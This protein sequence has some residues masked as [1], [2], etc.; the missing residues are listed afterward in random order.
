[1]EEERG[2]CLHRVLSY[3]HDVR[4][5]FCFVLFCFIFVVLMYAFMMENK[6]FPFKGNCTETGKE[7]E[8]R[9]GSGRGGYPQVLGCGPVSPFV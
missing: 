4:K 2:Q 7:S 1:M 8:G 6:L 9:T 3:I 5:R